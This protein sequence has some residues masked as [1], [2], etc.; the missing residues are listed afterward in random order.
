MDSWRHVGTGDDFGILYPKYWVPSRI[1]PEDATNTTVGDT[2]FTGHYGGSPEKLTSF[3]KHYNDIFEENSNIL[4]PEIT[5][6]QINASIKYS[7]GVLASASIN[8]PS[9]IKP[10]IGNNVID[11]K[12]G[13]ELKFKVY[14]NR[15][16]EIKYSISIDDSTQNYLVDSEGKLLK[17][18]TEDLDD[19]MNPEGVYED[20][21]LLRWEKEF[22]FTWNGKY[23]ASDTDKYPAYGKHRL[24]YKIVD[25]DDNETFKK[26]EIIYV[27]KVAVIINGKNYD[28]YYSDGSYNYLGSSINLSE[29]QILGIECYQGETKL[30]R[31]KF[32]ITYKKLLDN[33]DLQIQ[34]P[35]PLEGLIFNDVTPDGVIL[36]KET[37]NYTWKKSSFYGNSGS[38]KISIKAP[39]TTTDQKSE[40]FVQDSTQVDT[41]RPISL[42]TISMVFK[43]PDDGGK[44]VYGTNIPL[45]EKDTLR[46]TVP[47]YATE[48]EYW[49]GVEILMDGEYN[50]ADIA[51][52]EPPYT[53]TDST[54]VY[55][56]VWDYSEQP[57]GFVTMRAR[58]VDDP[59]S[60]DQKKIK[61]GISNTWEDFEDGMGGW[62]LGSNYGYPPG[63][64]I[65]ETNYF[66]ITSN[67]TTNSQELRSNS[68]GLTAHRF[69]VLS[70][71][72]TVPPATDKVQTF[73]FFDY[74]RELGLFTF[75]G[76]RSMVIMQYC[77]ES[78]NKLDIQPVGIG[79]L[80]AESGYPVPGYTLNYP[81]FYTPNI[82]G[83]DYYPDG[84]WTNHLFWLNMSISD[85]SGKRITIKFIHL[86][87]DMPGIIDN[88]TGFEYN[89]ASPTAATYHHIDNFQ[90]K[91]YYMIN[92]P[93]TI[94][95]V[96]DQ[97]VKQHC[98]W[99]KI[100]LTGITNGESAIYGD[101]TDLE[102]QKGK[103]DLLKNISMI[104][105][106]EE[107]EDGSLKITAF[108]KEDSTYKEVSFTPGKNSKAEPQQV[109]EIT[110]YSDNRVVIPADSLKLETEYAAGD[111]TAVLM[112][113]PED[114]ESGESN[115]TITVRDNGGVEHNGKDYTEMKFKI[116]VTP[117]NPP[118]Y[119][120]PITEVES[121]TEDFEEVTIYLDSHFKDSDGDKINYS[122]SADAS[123]VRTELING[124]LKIKSLPDVYGTGSLTIVADDSTGTVP[125]VVQI[126]INIANDFDDFEF[127][128]YEID[129]E[130]TIVTMFLPTNFDPQA[131]N[132]DEKIICELTG[133]KTYTVSLSNTETLNASVSGS[134]INL[135]PK[136]DIR[137]TVDATMGVTVNG[138]T[139][140]DKIKIIVGNLSPEVIAEIPDIETDA[141]FETMY[142][143][144]KDH[145][146]D[147]NKD[148]LGYSVRTT[149][150]KIDSYISFYD[151]QLI[152]ESK[153]NESGVDSLYISIYDGEFTVRDS[154]KI[155]IGDVETPVPY[156]VTPIPDQ[157]LKEDFGIKAIDLSQHFADPA[158]TGIAYVVDFDST[159]VKCSIEDGILIMKSVKNFHGYAPIMVSIDDG[160]KIIRDGKFEG[161]DPKNVVRIREKIKKK[162]KAQSKK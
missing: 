137:G 69:E 149:Q 160:V 155:T 154:L 123:L 141:N 52:A 40:L 62:T 161:C 1:S 76:Y 34:D 112:Y 145:F 21:A 24:Y 30:D 93:P 60:Y 138:R 119:E 6:Q 127:I 88:N 150:D 162:D 27:P 132:I 16:K 114:I 156:L 109:V 29:D 55:K 153:A 15:K 91:T 2:T 136:A 70:P 135:T 53:S 35:V 111:T 134:S 11:P 113:R 38:I 100:N 120:T 102:D 90:V 89:P 82:T 68:F 92:L 122:A 17:D 19:K 36:N 83:I 116:T 131:I 106:V 75:E 94:D 142:I 110:L 9:I 126:P 115:I 32:E 79:S 58:Y 8:L 48:P 7:A 77:D 14:E 129:E 95:E 98:G 96:A 43:K 139:V 103:A 99:Q 86:Y 56:F 85:L 22:S 118:V 72:I 10:I 97:E 67:S 33:D 140:T 42:G 159:K 124:V 121:I 151:D 144:L 25:M 117:F 78:G 80:D 158:G 57:E 4:N 104:K 31:T 49:G 37:Y 125:A 66:H 26:Y 147:P 3:W 133:T 128:E 28:S 146:T 87:T 65:P 39:Y 18:I 13:T 130:D 51:P 63:N 73:L 157:R 12:I 64:V 152:I 71:V 41:Y 59:L 23:K 108:V 44:Y 47:K 84:I 5:E 54:R 107:R 143:N 46:V 101:E 74:A 81:N 45:Q 20:G 61:V 148:W 50:R 105:D